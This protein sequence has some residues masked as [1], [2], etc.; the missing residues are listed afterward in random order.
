ML[1]GNSENLCYTHWYSPKFSFSVSARPLKTNLQFMNR[2]AWTQ[3]SDECSV[4]LP[5]ADDI[6]ANW[7]LFSIIIKIMI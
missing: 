5:A 4:S 6:I 3:T 2:L 1:C 7:N